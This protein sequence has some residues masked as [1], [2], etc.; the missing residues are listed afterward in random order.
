M[1]TI[2]DTRGILVGRTLL[3]SSKNIVENATIAYNMKTFVS[4]LKSAGMMGIL[5]SKGPFTL[6]VPTDSAFARIP[7]DTLKV[8]RKPDSKEKKEKLVS[9]LSYHIVLGTWHASDFE[10]GEKKLKTLHG[11]EIKINKKFHALWA[12]DALAQ[13]PN[14][15]SS[16][17]VIHSIDMVLMPEY[18]HAFPSLFE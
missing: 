8:L 4:M 7:L 6:F 18:S 3:L 5:E 14:I 10:E 2:N 16:N 13:T 1:Q 17:G 9:I 12:N 11:S 15:L